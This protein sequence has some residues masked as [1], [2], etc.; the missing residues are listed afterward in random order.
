MQTIVIY[1]LKVIIISGILLSYYWIALR[2]KRFHYY[3][4]FYLLISLLI[5][6]ALPL[7]NF[8]WFT[9][10]SNNDKAIEL[11][12]VITING[13]EQETVVTSSTGFGWKIWTAIAAACVTAFMLITFVAGVIKIYLLKKKY[14]ITNTGEF[15]FI[16]T[17]LQQ[18]PFSFFKNLFWRNDIEL[19]SETGEQILSHEITHIRQKHSWDK[20]FM[21]TLLSFFWTNPFFWLIRKELYLIHEFI[22][23]EKAVKNKDVTAFAN[24]MLTSCFGENIFAPAQ[25]FNYS[26]I[27]RRLVML[28]NSY[29]PNYPYLR[30]LMV[31][32]LLYCVTCLFSFQIEKSEAV[33]VKSTD[34]QNR[35]TEADTS[36]PKEAIGTVA[37][38]LDDI[39]D[40]A[41]SNTV[42]N[43]ATRI[44]TD[45]RSDVSDTIKSSPLYVL[46]GNIVPKKVV[47]NVRPEEIESIHV[48]KGKN[49][50]DKYGE[51]GKNGVVEID[52][53]KETG[54]KASI[55]SV[56]IPPKFPGGVDAWNKYLQRQLKADIVTTK[57]G[58]PG[59]Y[60][61]VVS[62]TVDTEGNLSDIKAE[63]DPGYGTAEEA[64]RVIKRGPKWI[65]AVQNG[66]NVTARTTQTITWEVVEQ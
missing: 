25:S 48:L 66:K 13:G 40:T 26:P 6:L 34:Q 56:Q 44:A 62:F 31:L 43:K 19:D 41:A 58:P 52:T 9:W 11:L 49:A 12:S 2:N 63:N 38:Q 5:S 54:G 35:S 28:T 10:H 39:K 53:K 59:T 1:Q 60:K 65:P 14:P 15:D 47:D 27:K 24:M 4:R 20:L 42:A 33:Q 17:D 18:A 46:D 51:K 37:V 29:K 8:T 55:D 22:A 57:G 64:A 7:F 21:Q 32:P 30:R 36:K 45:N 50:T 3:N 61:V 16:Q 23:D